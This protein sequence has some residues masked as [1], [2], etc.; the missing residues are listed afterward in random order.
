MAVSATDF[1]L[2]ASPFAAKLA[3]AMAAF[4]ARRDTDEFVN[5]AEELQRLRKTFAQKLIA[6]TDAASSPNA[7][8]DG[9]RSLTASMDAPV[10]GFDKNPYTIE[11]NE[12]LQES[13][14][15]CALRV[16]SSV[17]EMRRGLAADPFTDCFAS[18]KALSPDIDAFV[19]AGRKIVAGMDEL[20]PS[21]SRLS[22]ELDGIED[23]HRRFDGIFSTR[24]ET[25]E[26]VKKAIADA[27]TI[28]GKLNRACGLSEEYLRRARQVVSACTDGVD[29][30][31][32]VRKPLS[33][34]P[35]VGS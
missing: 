24:V 16:E 23:S 6:S 12:E 26:K 19:T 14:R 7:L 21:L 9:L 8:E 2:A 28:I 22:K 35:T 17:E 11:A 5:C 27:E 32:S 31:V 34:R 13:Y 30:T 10:P 20:P 1:N 18:Y 25:E 15:A 29:S 33:F 4:E 3:Q